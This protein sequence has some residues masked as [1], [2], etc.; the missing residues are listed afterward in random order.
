MGA[1]RLPRAARPRKDLHGS[2]SAARPGR[3][4]GGTPWRCSTSCSATT[5]TSARTYCAITRRCGGA[6]LAV[7]VARRSTARGGARL[8][9]V[10]FTGGEP[11][12][13]ADLPALV[14]HARRRGF[15]HVKVASNGLRYAH[16]AYLDHLV[17]CGVDR[18]HVS[19]HAH[20]DE[21]Y[22][23]TVRLAGTAPLRRAAI[24]NL[25]ARGL[26]PVADL[27]LKEDTY[28]GVR[29]WSPRSTRSAC[30]ATLWLVHRSP[31]RTRATSPAPR[32]GDVAREMAPAFEDARRGYELV[33]LHVRAASCPGTRTTC[34]TRA[35]TWSPW[36]RRT[37]CST[38]RTRASAA[39]C[40]REAAAAG[41]AGRA[42]PGLPRRLRG[43]LRGRGG[44]GG[45]GGG[46]GVDVKRPDAPPGEHVSASPEDDL[47]RPAP[48][49]SCYD[50]KIRISSI[51]LLAIMP[52]VADGA[53]GCVFQP[54]RAARHPRG[55]RQLWL[56]M[57]LRP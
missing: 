53:G 17:A 37:R 56:S 23:A 4:L 40:S 38:S 28:R 44:A 10:A 36:S 22:E 52:L 18:F 45:A 34:A 50:I 14:K 29:A 46:G 3:T 12:I 7:K 20:E 41:A 1:R 15:A 19:M 43:R 16:A 30:G 31:T 25:V 13:R 6:L 11:T 2:R 51:P 21:A 57:G 35:P 55:L 42:C 39:G 54:S 27:I 24:A 32:L 26:D 33:S 48:A 5:A 9:E 47:K 8:L 49:S